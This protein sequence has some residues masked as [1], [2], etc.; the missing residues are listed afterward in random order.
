MRYLIITIILFTGSLDLIC[1]K[2]MVKK[3]GTINCISYHK[4]YDGYQAYKNQGGDLVFY[5]PDEE[6]KKVIDDQGE[7]PKF[8]YEEVFDVQKKRILKLSVTGFANDSYIIQYEQPLGIRWHIEG[9][10]KLHDG[11]SND[12]P[13]YEAGGWGVELGTKYILDNP[14]KINKEGKVAHRMQHVYLK[15]TIGYSDRTEQGFEDRDEYN[16]YYGGGSIGTQFVLGGKIAIDIHAGAYYYSGS[17]TS[18]P[19][20]GAFTIPIILDPK[21]GDFNGENGIGTS[22]A[23]EIGFLF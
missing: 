16:M 10:I 13:F 19:M 7:I 18:T 2:I 17:G 15:P 3:D 4:Q 12:F 22:L 11:S 21:E 5:I 14:F 23:I 20:S 1:Q 9:G 6:V 8:L